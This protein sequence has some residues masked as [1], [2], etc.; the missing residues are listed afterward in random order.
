MIEAQQFTAGMRR[1]K[2]I[3]R[4]ADGWTRSRQIDAVCS[5]QFH[6]NSHPCH[7]SDE[8]LRYFHSSAKRGLGRIFLCKAET[9]KR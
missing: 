5:R 9:L 7:R 8:S 3:V 4:E 6:F 1:G 2:I